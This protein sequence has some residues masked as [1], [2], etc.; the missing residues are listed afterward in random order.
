MTKMWTLVQ[1]DDGGDPGDHAHIN[2]VRL[3]TSLQGV[4]DAFSKLSE[5]KYLRPTMS[6]EDME[7]DGITLDD[8]RA[9]PEQFDWQ[10]GRHDDDDTGW[11]GGYIVV[12]EEVEVEP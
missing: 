9:E 3:F 7:S 6:I 12:I 8:A 11:N 4:R 1:V 5:F 2:R 10:S